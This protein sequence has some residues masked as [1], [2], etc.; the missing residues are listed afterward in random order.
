MELMTANIL[1]RRLEDRPESLVQIRAICH[2]AARSGSDRL[3]DVP[4][5]S[6]PGDGNPVFGL[7]THG[8][9]HIAESERKMKLSE[10]GTFWVAA[11]A[12]LFFVAVGVLTLALGLKVWQGL[13][14]ALV[15]NALFAYVAWGSIGGVRSGLPTLTFARAANG[16]VGNRFH[17]LCAWLTSVAFEA[18]NT[19]LGVFAALALFSELGWDNPGDAGKVIALLTIL[20]ASGGLAYLGHATMVYVQRIFAVLLTVTLALVFVYTIGDV[21]WSA[22]PEEPLSG[23]AAWAAFFIAA[24]VVASGPLSYLFNC[25][26]YPRYL[27]AATP[28]RKIFWTVFVS[29]GSMALFLTVMGVLLASQGDMSD[30]VAGV[31]ALVP[32]WLFVVYALAV[33][34]GIVA[35][36]ILTFYSS[37][38]VMQAAGVPLRRYQ[39][40]LVD[41]VVA[42]LI[43]I[44]VLFVAEDFL[45]ELNNFV[46]TM[47][48]WIGP[49]GAVWIVDGM[50]RRWRYDPQ[51]IHNPHPGSKYWGRA[52]FNLHGSIAW[53]AGALVGWLFMN[54]PYYQGPL[55]KQLDGADLNWLLGFPVAAVVYLGLARLAP[56]GESVPAAVPPA[57]TAAGEPL[58]PV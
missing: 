30:P 33:L 25:A 23:G 35:N 38:L 57:M 31:V 1:G 37:G 52:G 50:L 11:N 3:R 39:A 2:L 55:A 15:G 9:D 22:G 16:Q 7:E 36:N 27:P 54:A 24:G 51:E 13:V 5:T 43:M 41:I 47:I 49:F 45:S 6:V 17:T 19:I 8:Y 46:A 58:D 40:T 29:S 34:G 44:Y 14:A 12:N 26:D 56:R 4:E 28:S 48:V 10:L 18:I 42:T 53:A 21:N 32:E 20:I